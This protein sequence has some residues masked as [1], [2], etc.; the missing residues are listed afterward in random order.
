MRRKQ[1][2]RVLRSI[3]AVDAAE[4]DAR[5][6]T[7]GIDPEVRPETLTPGDFAALLRTFRHTVNRTGSPTD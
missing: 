4:V 1:M 2:R 5:L 6:A 3:Y 7:L